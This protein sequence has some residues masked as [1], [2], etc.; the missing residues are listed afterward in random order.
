MDK[1]K[2]ILS[3]LRPA[4]PLPPPS[5]K[6]VRVKDA[7]GF[8]EAVSR[9]VPGSTILLA[10]G[11][12]SM[13]KGVAISANDVSIRGENGNRD[14]V[15]LD[16]FEH[17]MDVDSALLCVK[18]AQ[19]TLIADL[20]FQ[21]SKKYGLLLFGDSGAHGLN[22]YNIVFH[23]IWARGLKG[24]SPYR[25]NDSANDLNPPEVVAQ[26]RPRDG[27]VR[28]CLFIADRVKTDLADGYNGDYISGIDMQYLTNWT[29]ADNAFVGI[30]GAH[31]WGRGAI[32]LW[33]G[34][35]KITIERNVF[36]NCDRSI[37][38]GNPSS[39]YLNV[40][41]A[42]VRDNEIVAGANRAVECNWTQ[43]VDVYKNVIYATRY[44]YP[45]VEF[46]RGSEGC[47]FHHNIVHGTISCE[48]SART[49][50]NQLGN[51]E[52][53]FTEPENGNL[54]LTEKGKKIFGKWQFKKE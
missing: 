6:I 27:Q 46:I 19:R 28:H 4:P 32:F 16:G 18:G 41:G 29:I 43:D 45:T 15:I 42:V 39:E 24:T 20:T 10:D 5:G 47:R 49:E 51:L 17:F 34:S 53:C 38:L 35:E 50:Y 12:Y 48:P 52:G 9:A 11:V 2:S 8:C 26:V 31:G 13:P 40:R 7:G 30:Q 25:R 54:D 14:A 21:N 36:F 44:E 33:V 22:V 3:R 1:L 23:N 37:A